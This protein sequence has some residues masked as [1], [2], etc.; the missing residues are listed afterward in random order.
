M[1]CAEYSGSSKKLT[2]TERLQGSMALD[3][4]YLNLDCR[5]RAVE[6][7]QTRLDAKLSSLQA[8]AAEL[9]RLRDAAQAAAGTP[10]VSV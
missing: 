1:A 8:V 10:R 7:G 9:V 6:R 3:L 2:H 4:D 5:L